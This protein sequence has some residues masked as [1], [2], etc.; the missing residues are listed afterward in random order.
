MLE[1]IVAVDENYGIGKDG[2]LPWYV[3]EDLGI[4]KYK[5]MDSVLIVGRKTAQTLP[6]LNNREIVIL[7]KTGETNTVIKAVVKAKEYKKPIFVVGGAELYNEIFKNFLHLV[8]KIHISFISGVYN[9]DVTLENIP[10]NKFNCISRQRFK[11]FE[12]R[13]F[14]SANPPG[15]MQYLR[16]LD[17]V[18]SSQNFTYGR[19][20]KVISQFG[21]TLSFNLLNEFPLLTTKKMFLRGIVEEL[22]FFLRGQTDSKILEKKGVNI[23]KAN[24]E[25]RRGLMGPM[26]GSQWRHFGAKLEDF[27]SETS[28]Y[29]GGLDQLK[30]VIELIQTDPKSRR[31]LLTTFNPAQ[32]EFGVL[33][34]CHSLVNQFYV[35]GEYLNMTCYNR[36]S[37][38]FLGLPFNIASSALLLHI[39][40]KITQYKAQMLHI[41][42]GDCHIYESHINA[43]KT[44]LTRIPKPPPEILIKDF[45]SV[46]DLTYEHFCLQN[47]ESYESIKAEMVK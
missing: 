18:F 34:P 13:V 31:I 17:E 35:D 36:S 30:N 39:I 37:D 22:L 23:W 16:L 42:L 46:E 8:S 12:H 43:V 1:V 7:S 6:K 3:S 19:N 29:K 41:Y 24:T 25:E 11:D 44:Q 2:G 40:A 26:Y 33:Y 47:Y 27:D 20:G 28:I 4:F 14:V 10:L 21:K 45:H 38:L 32:V 9:C 5:T 15:E